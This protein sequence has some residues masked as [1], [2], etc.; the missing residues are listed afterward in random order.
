MAR[1]RERILRLGPI[2]HL[3]PGLRG[4]IWIHIEGK[5]QLGLVTCA[6]LVA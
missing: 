5:T 4:L 1:D 2:N 6:E 3:L